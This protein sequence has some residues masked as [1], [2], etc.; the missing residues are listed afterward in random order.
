MSRN[1]ASQQPAKPDHDD[2]E[3][4]AGA[5]AT[6]N[7]SPEAFNIVV[8]VPESIEIRMVDAS[9]LADYE[10]WVFIASILSNAAVAY[11]VAYDQAADSKS[12]SLSYIGWTATIFLVLL[13]LSI[14]AAVYKRVQLRRKG[15]DIKLKTSSASTTKSA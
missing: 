7:P 13:G 10:I 11:L 5:P 9:S 8:H 3:A 6:E 4:F 14:T 2:A 15:R 12:P 1:R